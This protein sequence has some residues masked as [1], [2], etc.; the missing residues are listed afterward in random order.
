[1]SHKLVAFV[2]AT[3][4]SLGGVLTW[5]VAGAGSDGDSVVPA[6]VDLAKDAALA[7]DRKLPMVLV[8]SAADCDYC[9]LLEREI[10][11]PMYI[12]RHYKNRVVLR[13]VMTDGSGKLRDFNG[14]AVDASEFAQ[15]YNV[16]V[17]PTVVFVDT[18][19]K[20]LAPRLLGINTVEMYF[21][22]LDQAIEASYQVMQGRAP[23]LN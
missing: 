3:L 15:H 4:L 12:S 2:G 10:L 8:F 22:Y 5:G 1:M 18:Q 16:Q 9:H 13:R 20:E 23:V 6:T 7:R 21:A 19:G 17:T 14:A 11:D